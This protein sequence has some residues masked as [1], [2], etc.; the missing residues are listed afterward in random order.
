[1]R[2]MLNS[3]K[4]EPVRPA[5]WFCSKRICSSQASRCDGSTGKSQFVVNRPTMV[6]ESASR[7]SAMVAP[8]QARD[9]DWGIRTVSSMSSTLQCSERNRAC[10]LLVVRRVKGTCRQEKEQDE[11]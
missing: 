9:N 3:R 8:Y 11:D 6:S 1:M 4:T 7:N 10:F 5:S 2:G